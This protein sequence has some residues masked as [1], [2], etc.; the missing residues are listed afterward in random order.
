[1]NGTQSMGLPS[2]IE[3]AVDRCNT[4]I[5][6]QNIALHAFELRVRSLG[7]KS[8][9]LGGGPKKLGVLFRPRACRSG[10]EI[11]EGKNLG[12][13][14]TGIDQTRTF[15]PQ[16]HT[17]YAMSDLPKILPQAD[18]VCLTLPLTKNYYNWFTRKELDLM[19]DDSI[20]IV[21]GSGETVN[22]DDLYAISQSGKLRGVMIDAFYQMPIPP[23][24]PLWK[25]E[26]II[27]TPEVSPRPK[28]EEKVS[29]QLFRH[30][31]RQYLSGNYADMRN[32]IE[33]TSNLIPLRRSVYDL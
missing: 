7:R 18:I 6:A 16:C 1:M 3:E 20:L 21:A 30:N 12:L 4:F 25:I 27:I 15:H 29:F 31:L 24:S 22:E 13:K 14:V 11:C 33:E 28:S 23:T 5:I 26:N 9:V 19:K 32:V 8:V 2:R 10:K 17:T